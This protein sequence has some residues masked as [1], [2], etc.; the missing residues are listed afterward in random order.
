[1]PLPET[2]LAQAAQ[3]TKDKLAT[4]YQKGLAGVTAVALAMLGAGVYKAPFADSASL[5][6]SQPTALTAGTLRSPQYLK[7]HCSIAVPINVPHGH[8]TDHS[9]GVSVEG[10]YIH[11]T[12]DGTPDEEEV[13][14]TWHVSNRDKFCGIV[15]LG[16]YANAGLSLAPLSETAHGGHYVDTGAPAGQPGDPFDGLVQEFLVYAAPK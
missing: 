15:G 5:K 7:D 8:P 10:K 12:V 4:H 13:Q 1:M 11:A 2:N 9:D 16:G 14:Y 6:G 3:Y